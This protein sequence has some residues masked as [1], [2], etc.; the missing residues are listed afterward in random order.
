VDFRPLYTESLQQGGSPNSPRAGGNGAGGSADAGQDE[1]LS[2]LDQVG[3][4]SLVGRRL[5]SL[6]S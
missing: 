5:H 6:P 2:L 3:L 1:I 4:H